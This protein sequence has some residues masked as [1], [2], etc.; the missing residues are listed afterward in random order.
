MEY[1]AAVVCGSASP[2]QAGGQQLVGMYH[3]SALPC[4]QP[5]ASNQLVFLHRC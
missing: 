1:A 3:N 2:L 5:S 4:T